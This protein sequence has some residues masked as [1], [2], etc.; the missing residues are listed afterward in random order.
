MTNDKGQRTKI[1]ANPTKILYVEDDPGSQTLVS[2][3]LMAEGYQVL[4]ADSG[5]EGIHKASAER[6]DMILMDIN[7]SD[8]DGYEVT[9]KLRSLKSLKDVPI[10]AVT[11]NVLKGDKE[12]ALIA[13][14][15]GY[16]S[17]PIDVDA[18]PDQ[19]KSFLQGYQETVPPEEQ[20][21]YLTEYNRQIVEH[22]ED[23]VRKLKEANQTLQKLEKMKSDFIILSAHELRTPLTMAYGYARILMTTEVVKN[24][25]LSDDEMVKHLAEKIFS[26]INRLNEVVNDILNIALI[27]AD[28]MVLD[29]G[30]VSLEKVINSALI[31]L[32]PFEH[33]RDLNINIYP[34]L[35]GLPDIE[36]D[37]NRLRQ[38]FW[39]LL[40]NA[41]KYT[42]D[43]GSISVDGEVIDDYILIRVS[44]TGIGIKKEEQENIFS[45]FYISGDTTHH[46]SH[47]VKFM[48]GG[49]GIGLNIV[50]GIVNAH[51]GS[52]YVKSSGI[53]GEGAVFY[54][55]L[56]LKQKT[57]NNVQ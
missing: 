37:E 54:V 32:D 52:V 45:S 26:S 14:C 19:V 31:E 48:G 35:S 40:S 5:L 13:G 47:K 25:P 21:D 12:R 39:N 56:P 23:K 1:M 55:S 2:R 41:V 34:P 43:G 9:T 44:D 30:F 53:P 4:L 24:P 33:G 42:P 27:Q 15:T 36:A 50:K 51:Q 18:F 8:L 38:V 57:E 3:V 6:P 28:E 7:I 11:A 10:V 46:S 20:I 17:K 29:I 22:L 16:I 49:M